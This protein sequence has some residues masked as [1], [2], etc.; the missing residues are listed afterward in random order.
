VRVSRSENGVCPALTLTLGWE[1]RRA[2]LRVPRTLPP[3]KKTVLPWVTAS[4]R[5][6][7][8]S[9]T[10]NAPLTMITFPLTRARSPEFP[11]WLTPMRG[12]FVETVKGITSVFAPEVFVAATKR[13]P[14]VRE[15]G[16][17]TTSGNA[18]DCGAAVVKMGPLAA[19]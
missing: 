13:R 8:A 5:K 12:G 16:R 1:T 3:P 11:Q 10:A 14:F 19:S 6:A 7:A 4:M 9:S 17:R 15:V 18:C 2:N